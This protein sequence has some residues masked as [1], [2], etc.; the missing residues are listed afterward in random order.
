ML[1]VGGDCPADVALPR[2]GSGLF[3]PVASAPTI[4]RLIDTMAVTG[5]EALAALR[6]ACPQ[7]RARVQDLSPG[8]PLDEIVVDIEAT[9]VAAHSEKESATLTYKRG[10]GFH[11]PL[12]S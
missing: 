3:G 12:M 8:S 5:D 10:F 2:T 9:L 7:A 11:H 1:A 6:T 4:S